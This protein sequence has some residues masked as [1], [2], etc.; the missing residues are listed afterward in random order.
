MKNRRPT[1]S[2]VFSRRTR[3]DRLIAETFRVPPGPQKQKRSSERSQ[4]L[5][6][7]LLDSTTDT[8]ASA[9]SRQHSRSVSVIRQRGTSV[10]CALLLTR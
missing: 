1:E 5:L 4:M 9:I 3:R 6:C 2:G 8:R 10:I 7:A